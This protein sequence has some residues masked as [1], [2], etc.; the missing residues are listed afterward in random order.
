MLPFKTG[1][2]RIAKATNEPVVMVCTSELHNKI[3]LNRWD[4]GVLVI[5]LSDPQHLDDSKDIKQWADF[6]HGQMK[7]RIE[8]INEEVEQIEKA[9]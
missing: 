7:A 2:F 6:F 9:R 1:A 4:N 3:N 5:E 8:A